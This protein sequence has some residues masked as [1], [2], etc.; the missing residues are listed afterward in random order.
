MLMI[1]V[2]WL[3]DKL[4]DTTLFICLLFSIYNNFP[5][6]YLPPPFYIIFTPLNFFMSFLLL[7][8]LFCCL[9]LFC[10]VS[11]SQAFKTQYKWCIPTISS[12][13]N[14]NLWSKKTLNRP[15]IFVFMFVL[16]PFSPSIHLFFTALLSSCSILSKRRALFSLYLQYL[17][18]CQLWLGFQWKKNGLWNYTLLNNTNHYLFLKVCSTC[19]KS[20]VRHIHETFYSLPCRSW[21]M[22][23]T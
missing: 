16:M 8:I 4:V 17:L 5:I 15:L 22:H 23:F 14:L 18:K 13:I 19:L 2:A 11:S 20:I 3:D 10:L 9:S 1:L 12:P 6:T 7:G 21:G